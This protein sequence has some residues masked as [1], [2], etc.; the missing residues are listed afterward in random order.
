[1]TGREMITRENIIRT[2][3][4]ALEPLDYVNAMWE[5]GA[6]AFDRV[7]EW[8]D[9]DICVDAEDVRVRDVFP[10]AEHA[11]ASLS[12]I[13]LKYDILQPT[14][15]DYV[16]AFYR[17]EGT[18]RYMLVDFAVFKHSSQDKLLEPRIHGTPRFHFNKDNAVTCPTFDVAGF[19]GTL[20]KRAERVQQ[21]FDMF[22]CFVIKELERGHY[23]EALSLYHRF[24]LD[25]LLAA[26]RIRYRPVHYDFKTNYLSYDLPTDV[27]GRLK[28]FYFVR[29]EK[30]LRDK[31]ELASQWVHDTLREI[32]F[33]VIEKAL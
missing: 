30:D 28:D 31:H 2:L 8:S 14:L 12:S 19:V 7:D 26:L 22:G 4:Q 15:G 9:I 3:V 13:E 21:R 23:I 29:D 1:V 27:V 17:L 20:K 10:V 6:V 24:T 5:G 32:D 33:D 18:N 16:Q 11:L 25:S